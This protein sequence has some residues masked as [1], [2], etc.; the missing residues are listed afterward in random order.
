[1]KLNWPVLEDVVPTSS[2]PEHRRLRLSDQRRGRVVPAS[3]RKELR[4]G[5][6][7]ILVAPGTCL[8]MQISSIA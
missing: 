1:M 4:T 8:S 2:V 5:L 7:S 6:C 3:R